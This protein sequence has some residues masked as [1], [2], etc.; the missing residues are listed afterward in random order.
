MCTRR[1]RRSIR[2]VLTN[3]LSNSHVVGYLEMIGWFRLQID[4]DKRLAGSD[5]FVDTRAFI[6]TNPTDE[7]ITR[8]SPVI[9]PH[10]RNRA[11]KAPA[12]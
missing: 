2:R 5:S 9:Y 7:P 4:P 1:L 12:R 8:G 10:T 3:T 11:G 6:G